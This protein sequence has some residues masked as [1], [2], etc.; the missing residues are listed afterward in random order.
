MA[1]RDFPIPGILYF[2]RGNPFSGSYKGMSYRLDPVKG[3]AEENITAH[4]DA[5]VWT[6]EKCSELSEMRATAV[7]SLDTDGLTAAEAWL[8]EQYVVLAAEE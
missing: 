1:L 8:R 6:G 2:T 5:C 4:I 7:F 3:K